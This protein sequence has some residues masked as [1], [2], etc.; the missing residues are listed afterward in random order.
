MFLGQTLGAQYIYWRIHGISGIPSFFLEV[1]FENGNF[2]A[3]HL[4]CR[5]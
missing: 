3:A 5:R 1:S 2:F 4:Y